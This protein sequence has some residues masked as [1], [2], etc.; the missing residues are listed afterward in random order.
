M[1]KNKNTSNIKMCLFFEYFANIYTF[2]SIIMYIYTNIGI[3]LV[4]F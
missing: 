4:K 1:Y 2:L 3:F